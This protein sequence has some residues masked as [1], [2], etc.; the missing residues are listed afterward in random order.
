MI[1]IDPI[2]LSFVDKILMKHIGDQFRVTSLSSDGGLW[3]GTSAGVLLF[4]TP[5]QYDADTGTVKEEP[6]ICASYHGHTTGIKFISPWNGDFGESGK[7]SKL[8]LTGGTGYEFR[9]NS[10][11]PIEFQKILPHSGS[12]LLWSPQH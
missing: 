10:K 6:Q 12:V 7:H 3:V 4:I 8:V 2:N 11:Y 5:P 1:F 9:N